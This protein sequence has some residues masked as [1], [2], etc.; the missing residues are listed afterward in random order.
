MRGV[1]PN[2]QHRLS[3]GR[4]VT[5]SGRVR[6]ARGTCRESML[7]HF[8]GLICVAFARRVRPC[9]RGTEVRAPPCERSRGASGHPEANICNAFG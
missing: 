4:N 9:P 5:L 2:K 3:S 1:S 6:R 7:E 8:H